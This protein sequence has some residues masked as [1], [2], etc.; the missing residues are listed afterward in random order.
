MAVR[1]EQREEVGMR[2]AAEVWGKSPQH[3]QEIAVFVLITKY[4][5]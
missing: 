1:R 2:G 4:K 5:D 3:I